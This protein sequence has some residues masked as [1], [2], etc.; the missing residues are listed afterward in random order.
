[1]RLHSS[2]REHLHGL[3]VEAAFVANAT[4]VRQSGEVDLAQQ[5]LEIGEELMEAGSFVRDGREQQPSGGYMA[6]QFFVLH[7]SVSEQP[8][9]PDTRAAY[10]LRTEH[11]QLFGS[12]VQSFSRS[13]DCIDGLLRNFIVDVLA[14]LLESRHRAEQVPRLEVILVSGFLFKDFHIP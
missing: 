3:P 11:F 4:A 14:N 12:R 10:R 7:L 8:R 2:S 5:L 9:L 6:A 1:M 13:A